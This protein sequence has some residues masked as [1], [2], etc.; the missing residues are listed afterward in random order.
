[1]ERL[2]RVWL[3]NTHRGREV[4]THFGAHSTPP[5]SQEKYM[6]YG[7]GGRLYELWRERAPFCAMMM[8]IQRLR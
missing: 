2:Y 6:V 4:F 1:M 8:Y 7:V 3:V 5:G